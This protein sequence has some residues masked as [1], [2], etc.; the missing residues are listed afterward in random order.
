MLSFVRALLPQSAQ[1]E[2]AQ[3]KAQLAAVA[4]DDDD[5]DINFDSDDDVDMPGLF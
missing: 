3:L 1:A 2:I 5:D 4:P